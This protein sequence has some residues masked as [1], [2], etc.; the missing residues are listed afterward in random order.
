MPSSLFRLTPC[1]PLEQ[2][3]LNGIINYLQLE[4]RVKVFWRV[5][6]GGR[7]VKNG[8]IWFYKL[9]VGRREQKGKGLPDIIG[10]LRGGKIL[11]IEVKRP[12]EKPTEEQAEFLS[13]VAECGGVSGVAN[14]WQQAKAILS[15]DG[16]QF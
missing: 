16:S 1:N 8:F 15:E 6:G 11:A 10:V 7:A 9:F 14:N 3:R 5:N 2:E 13:M 4:P 12:G